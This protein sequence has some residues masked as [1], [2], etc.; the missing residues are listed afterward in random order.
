[1]LTPAERSYLY[2]SFRLRRCNEADVRSIAADSLLDTDTCRRMLTTIMPLID[3]PDLAITA[4]LYVKRLA[5]LTTGNVLYAMSVFDKGLILSLSGSQLEYAHDDGLWTSSLP[6]DM[7]ESIAP[8]EGRDQW[9]EAIVGA[10][11][12]D[13]LSPLLNVLSQVSGIPVQILWENIAVRVYSLYRGRMEGLDSEQAQRC[14]ADYDWLLRQADA[15]VFGLPWNPLKRFNRP[16]KQTATGEKV[17]FRRTCCFY[18]KATS[19]VE[20]CHNCPLL[21]TKNIEAATGHKK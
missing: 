15:T 12:K 17:R 20:Y 8:C 18:Y 14:Q 7:T 13:F 16:L 4:S 11:F 19:P 21:I 10:L 1:M 5:F 3:A 9:R 2:T 6:A